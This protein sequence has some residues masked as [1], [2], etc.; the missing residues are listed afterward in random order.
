[1][2]VGMALLSALSGA[3][4]ETVPWGMDD[5]VTIPL[6]VGLVLWSIG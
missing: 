1:L 2:P 4:I 5:N 3:L 6:G